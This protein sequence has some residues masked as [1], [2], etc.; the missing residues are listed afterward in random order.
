MSKPTS[1]LGLVDVIM[2]EDWQL[3]YSVITLNWLTR[4]VR[5]LRRPKLQETQSIF[6]RIQS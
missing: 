6:K 1:N 4:I 5:Y 2:N 3:K